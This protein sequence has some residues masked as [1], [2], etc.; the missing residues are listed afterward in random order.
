VLEVDACGR[1]VTRAM[2]FGTEKH[3]L[4]LQCAQEKLGRLIPG[5]FSI[6]PRYRYNRKTG[7][8]QLVSPAEIQ[9]LLR[10]K[11]SEEL[12]GTLSPDVII[13]A[14]DPLRV[15]GIYDFKFPCPISNG[16]QWYVYPSGHPYFKFN[17]GEIYQE[18]LG[19]SPLLVAPV[20]K[21]R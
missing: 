6:E 10:G 3:A 20:W 11:C 9:V 15:L 5:S 12:V 18:A 4:A 16:P 2:R 21:I 13:H 14:G 8:K 17:Q 1:K 19:V 7:Q